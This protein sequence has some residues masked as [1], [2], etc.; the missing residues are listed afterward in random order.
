MKKYLIT[1]L[2]ILTCVISFA[3]NFKAGLNFGF[4]NTD[5]L[6]TDVND[7]DQDF[8][9]LGLTI[10][11]FAQ[12]PIGEKSHIG[13]E[14]NFIEKGT[15]TPFPIDSSGAPA[16]GS[17]SFKLR[18]NY[19]EV[20]ILY[21]HDFSFNIGKKLIDHF[22]YE[23]GPSIGFLIYS[24]VNIDQAGA[25]PVSNY[26]AP[27]KGYDISGLIGIAY[28]FG[29]NWKLHIRYE[30]SLV[31]IHQHASGATGF[32]PFYLYYNPGEVNMVFSYSLS[33]TF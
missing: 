32:N 23:I 6:G 31:A 10:G 12:L 11:L 5:V 4:D 17:H 9:K 25:V 13:F 20:P 18:L 19:I 28:R 26:Y 33:Y 27:Y 29:D 2:I 7:G 24:D 14:M 21:T 16:Y 30:N 3:Q 1:L 22:S 8:D 15:Y